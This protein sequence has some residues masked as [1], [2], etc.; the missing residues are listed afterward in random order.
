[1]QDPPPSN[2]VVIGVIERSQGQILT[3]RQTARFPRKRARHL[4]VLL[5]KEKGVGG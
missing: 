1:M 4:E 3:V 2:A 5:L